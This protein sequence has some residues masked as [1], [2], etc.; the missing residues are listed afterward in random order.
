MENVSKQLELIKRGVTEIISEAQLKD[1]LEK[2]ISSEKPLVVKAGFDPSAP[3]IHLGH[4]VLLRKMRHF[5]DL[6]H[7]VIFLIGDFT[8]MIGDPS[9]KSEIR[10]QLTREQVLE[11]ANTYQ[12]QIYKI[13]DPG[14]TEIKFNSSW[15]NAMTPYEFL[16]L[17]S[18]LTVAQMLARDDFKK[19][20]AQGKDISILEFMYPLLQGYDSVVLNADIELGGTDQK[21][22][23][24]V[25]RQIQKDFQQAQQ[26]VLMMP[27]LEGLDGVQKMSKSLNNYVGIDEPADQMYGKLMSISDPLMFRYYELL[28]NVSLSEI[29]EKKEAVSNGSLH[30]KKCKEELAAQITEFYHN[31][32]QAQ[33]AAYLFSARHGKK[34]QDTRE[35]NVALDLFEDRKIAKTEWKDGKL[36]ICKALLLCGAVQS[37]AQARRLI[38]QSAVTLNGEKIIDVNYEL[39]L[40]SSE[41]KKYEFKIGKKQY[42]RIIID[43]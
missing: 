30:P 24:L 6:G 27:L 31:K 14:K 17:T 21:F 18:H 11:N 10:K 41:Q 9:G 16:Q 7:K 33:K 4:T 23:L 5:Q 2:S 38:I 20:Y 40:D 8:G 35:M 37:N 43:G 12:K 19:R 25:G 39:M 29:A 32:E 34:T 22:N 28:T 26:V 1:K 15:F 3:D 42:V 13:L 36:W